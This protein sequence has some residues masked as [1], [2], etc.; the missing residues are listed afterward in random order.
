MDQEV[1]RL[2]RAAVAYREAGHGV[3]QAVALLV[4]EHPVLREAP[5]RLHMV[6]R[7]AFGLSIADAKSIVSWVQG[8]ISRELLEE[9]LQEHE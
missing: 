4:H 3:V 9:W 7:S 5:F 2:A 1:E 6:L 8:D